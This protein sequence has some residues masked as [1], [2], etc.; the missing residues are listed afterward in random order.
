MGFYYWY[1][2]MDITINDAQL[3]FDYISL[4][5]GLRQNPQD[6]PC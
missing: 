3:N 4:K 2:S 6:Y 1:S 5:N